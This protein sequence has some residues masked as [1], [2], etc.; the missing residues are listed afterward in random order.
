MKKKLI[1]K[2]Y[3][4]WQPLIYQQPVNSDVVEKTQERLQYLS[5][6]ADEQKAKKELKEKNKQEKRDKLFTALGEGATMENTL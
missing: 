2:H 5:Q 4:T 3:N 6:H 1:S